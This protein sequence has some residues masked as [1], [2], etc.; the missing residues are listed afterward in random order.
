[1]G[2][3][4]LVTSIPRRCCPLA[5]SFC[6][7][8]STAQCRTAD[9]RTEQTDVQD[10]R[11][12]RSTERA[13]FPRQRHAPTV[14]IG[15]HTALTV[16]QRLQ[17]GVCSTRECYLLCGETINQILMP[18]LL[19]VPHLLVLLHSR[20]SSFACCNDPIILPIACCTDPQLVFR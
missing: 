10:V 13:H 3:C 14:S 8:S 15:A 16:V 20:H 5:R 7:D 6:S 11:W 2:H 18:S 17:G 12:H 9:L 1:M 4:C 19:L